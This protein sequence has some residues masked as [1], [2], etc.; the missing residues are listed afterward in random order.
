[1]SAQ[2]TW[3][4]MR[5]LIHRFDTYTDDAFKQLRTN[6]I[7]DKVAYLAS[8]AADYSMLWHAIGITATV[9]TPRLLPKSVRL[10]VTL[11]IESILV[12]GVMKELANRERPELLEDRLHHVRRPK[13]SSFPSGHASSAAVMA[14]LMSDAVPKLRPIWLVL[15]G[16]VGA[17]R[18]HNRMHYGTDVAAG[19]V[20][21]TI[22]GLLSKRVWKL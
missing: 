16:V 8:E 4:L 5:E 15:A 18:I 22:I 19:A 20:I 17:S 6:R 14:V 1:M 12:N 9:L 11:G 13:T 10:A 2:Y 7:A 21:G 3:C